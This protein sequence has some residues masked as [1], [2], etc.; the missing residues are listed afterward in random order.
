MRTAAAQV[1][2][3]RNGKVLLCLNKLGEF[4]GLFTGIIQR[5]SA[6][7]SAVD[8]ALRGCRQ[9]GLILEA[10]SLCKRAVLEMVE[11]DDCLEEHE[12][13]YSGSFSGEPRQTRRSGFSW[14]ALD[15][16]P[17]G[18]MPQDDAVWY[19][20]VL[21]NGRL[22]RGRFEFTEKGLMDYSIQPVDTL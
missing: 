17:F 7:E 18:D 15:G 16:L 8:A 9:A 20:E 14:F 6:G 1:L 10:S 11:G 22:L 19:P 3:V 12:F 4:K 5:C 2:I 13:V 21:V